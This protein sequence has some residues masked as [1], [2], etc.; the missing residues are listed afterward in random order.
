M[1]QSTDLSW[2]TSLLPEALLIFSQTVVVFC[3]SLQML[4]DDE[5]DYLVCDFYQFDWPAIWQEVCRA[6]LEQ[7][8]NVFPFPV[9]ELALPIKLLFDL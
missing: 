1:S 5:G 3:H 2:C 7:E 8:R 4:C 6:F 9:L